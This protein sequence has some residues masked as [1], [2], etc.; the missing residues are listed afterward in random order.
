M[1]LIEFLSPV[2]RRKKL[3]TLLVLL[4]SLV[5]FGFSQ[6]IPATEKTTV[7]F[8]IKVLKSE[9]TMS[10][11][12]PE[13]ASKIAEAIAGWAKNPAFRKE[14][15]NRSDVYISNFKRKV[16]ARKQNRINVFWTF[17]LS[18]TE[19][20]HSDR[21]VSGFL[22]VLNERIS[23]LSIN[24]AFPFEVSEAEIAKEMTIYPIWWLVSAAILLGIFFGFSSIYILESFLG[25]VSFLSQIRDVFFDS[26]TLRVSD[27]IKNHDKKILESFILTFDNPRLLPGFKNAE[28]FFAFSELEEINIETETPIL[29]IKLGVTTIRD[30]ENFQAV[31][32]NSVGIVVFER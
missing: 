9:N 2:I 28:K 5:F 15:L 4:F 30:L 13:S 21:I 6:M 27:K 20:K 3:T 22:E 12:V 29:I 24:S 17:K 32:G 31:F 26:P 23:A 14:I 7:Y 8:S 1:S 10:M 16:T 18:E 19:K 11:D 25:K